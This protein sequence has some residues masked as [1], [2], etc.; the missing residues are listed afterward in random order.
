MSDAHEVR[1]SVTCSKTDEERLRAAGFRPIVRWVNTTAPSTDSF[2]TKEALRIL[3]GAK[4]RG[5][6]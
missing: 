2:T 5:K 1:A 6:R 3:D 4:G